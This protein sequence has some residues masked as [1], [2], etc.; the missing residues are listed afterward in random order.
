MNIETTDD[1][2]HYL[3]MPIEQLASQVSQMG[4]KQQEILRMY[5]TGYSLEEISQHLHCTMS[6]IHETL[7]RSLEL[8]K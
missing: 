7:E 8:L 5:I 1:T 4:G 6:E 3:T 2:T